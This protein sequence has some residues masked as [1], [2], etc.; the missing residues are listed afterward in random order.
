MKMGLKKRRRI[1]FIIF[2]FIALGISVAVLG[3][4]FRKGIQYYRM[5]SEVLTNPPQESE[6]F[7]IGGF[8]SEGSIKRLADGSVS[9]IIVDSG[10]AVP[11]IYKGVLP[12]LFEENQGAIALGKYKNNIFEAVQ[13]LAKHDENYKPKILPQ[14]MQE[15]GGY[16]RKDNG[17]YGAN[18]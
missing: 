7:R 3:F 6:L 13:I 17:S 9:F 4:G 12:D 10:G 1:W 11:V 18:K 5:P 16:Y 15:S 14:N 2:A 8:V